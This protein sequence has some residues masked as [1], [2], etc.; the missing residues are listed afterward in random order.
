MSAHLM[1]VAGYMDL[2]PAHKLAFMK[3]CDSSDDRTRMAFPGYAALMVWTGVK[4]SRMKDVLR[5]LQDWGLL[6]VVKRAYRSSR[7]TYKVFPA[8]GDEVMYDPDPQKIKKGQEDPCPGVDKFGPVPGIP[9]ADEVARRSGFSEGATP[10]APSQKGPLHRPLRDNGATPPAPNAEK[11]PVDDEKGADTPAPFSPVLQNTS[12]PPSGGENRAHDAHPHADTISANSMS[13]PDRALN[14]NARNTTSGVPKAQGRGAMLA[15][16]WVPSEQML[17]VAAVK[18]PGIDLVE[19]TDKFRDHFVGNTKF[20]RTAEGWQGAWRN[21][22]RESWKR[23]GSPQA[24]EAPDLFAAADL[25]ATESITEP[26][27]A[28]W[29]RQ[30]TVVTPALRGKLGTLVAE[31]LSAGATPERIK[32]ALKL[33]KEPYPAPFRWDK[34]MAGIDPYAGVGGGSG[35]GLTFRQR[36]QRDRE[37]QSAREWRRVAERMANGQTSP[38]D[39]IREIIRSKMEKAGVIPGDEDSTPGPAVTPWAILKGEIAQ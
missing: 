7:T 25:A 30:G 21:W 24:V 10:P 37:E 31:A 12:L 14:D 17:A 8:P 16:D 4:K 39:S 35:D 6:L 29:A 13:T 1:I 5:D 19:E 9:D 32:E 18:H 26:W 23:A 28:Y 27:L 34:A 2:P 20:R 38:D 3:L 33:C 11:G 15:A 36:D 22:M